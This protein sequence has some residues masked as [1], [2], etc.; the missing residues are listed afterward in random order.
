MADSALSFLENRQPLFAVLDSARDT[1]ILPIVN[2]AAEQHQ[3]LFEGAKGEKLTTAAPYLVAL[4]TGSKLLN[5][6]IEHWG[7]SWGVFLTSRAPFSEVRRHFR[8]F[9][10]VKSGEGRQLYFRFYDPR[11]LRV[12][13]PSCKPVEAGEFFG[14][15]TSYLAEAEEPGT[16]LEF[17]FADAE[18]RMQRQP[19]T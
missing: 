4:P 17:T 11:V 18:C 7:Q 8:R 12:Y 10:L 9:L 13:L 5:Q 3:S 1:R 19:V 14:P 6:V 15:V 16:L 2:G